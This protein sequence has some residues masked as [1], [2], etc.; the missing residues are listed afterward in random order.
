V[1]ILAA[2]A[3][4]LAASLATAQPQRPDAASPAELLKRAAMIERKTAAIRGLRARRPIAKGVLSRD[5]ILARV[6]QKLASEYTPE[7]IGAEAAL[8]KRLGLVPAALDYK[9]AVLEL[10]KDQVAG[11]YDPVERKL[12]L[13]DWVP[14]SLQ[15]PALAHEI[16]HALQDQHFGLRKLVKP[17]KDDTDRQL[18]RAALVEGDCTGVMIE[19]AIAPRDLGALEGPGGRALRQLVAAGGTPKFKAAPRY[20]REVLLFPYTAGLSLIQRVRATHPWSTVSTMFKRL[21]ASTEQVLHPEKYWSNEQPVRIT[22]RPLPALADHELVKTD[23]LGEFQLGVYLG[24]GVEESVAQRAAAGWGGDLIAA[25][26][27]KGAPAA[28]LVL[29]HLASWDSEADALEFANAARHVL[30]ARKLAA[31]AGSGKGSWR[32]AEAGGLEWSVQLVGEHVLTVG[33]APA[34]TRATIAR[35]VLQLWRAG[36]KRLQSRAGDR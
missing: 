30:A 9:A 29:V 3:L 7:E 19:Y 24:L 35:E 22:A 1:R 18:A 8:L 28:P 26:R 10:M 16:C 12:H 13:A 27:R 36:G 4:V 34:A 32:F 5:A 14:L 11:Y 15:D 2:F 25:Y 6:E 21:P 31:V 33:G 17:L 23:V 20:L